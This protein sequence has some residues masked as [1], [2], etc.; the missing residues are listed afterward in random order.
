MTKHKELFFLDKN[1]GEIS[2]PERRALR[3]HPVR[4]QKPNMSQADIVQ[5]LAVSVGFFRS[6]SVDRAGLNVRLKHR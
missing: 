6:V 2:Q 4:G 5:L 3:Y 1:R